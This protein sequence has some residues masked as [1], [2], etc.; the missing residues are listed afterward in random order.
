MHL[1]W[2]SLNVDNNAAS[3]VLCNALKMQKN[4]VRSG[5]ANN[6]IYIAIVP[7]LTESYK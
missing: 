7:L 3:A 5:T 1:P 6:N 4:S 2:L